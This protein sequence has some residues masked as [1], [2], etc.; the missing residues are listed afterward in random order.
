MFWLII[1]YW[2][3]SGIYS[4]FI[5][6]I[7]NWIIDKSRLCYKIKITHWQNVLYSQLYWNKTQIKTSSKKSAYFTHPDFSGAKI[8]KCAN[9]ASKYVI[10]LLNI[11]CVLI[12]SINF[13][14]NISH[15]KKN[16]PIWDQKCVSSWCKVPSL[17]SDF[18][19]TWTHSTDFW[20][21]LQYQIL[22]KSIQQESS[23]SIRTDG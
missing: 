19:K 16:W 6:I 15:S 5:M 4:A 13:V 1:D 23:R 20:N 7:I 21:I 9:Y 18:N 12:F 10:Y 2:I 3:D 8:K 14:W 22:W 11:K 17:L